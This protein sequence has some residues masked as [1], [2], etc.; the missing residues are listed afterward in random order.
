MR[1]AACA[2]SAVLLSGCSWLGSGGGYSD[3]NGYGYNGV[4]NNCMPGA[5]G[6]GFANSAYGYT[7]QYQSNQYMNQ[8]Y[9]GS[10]GLSLIHI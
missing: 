7:N 9:G 6:A 3:S 10:T 5:G 4:Y 1:L 8:A 2:L